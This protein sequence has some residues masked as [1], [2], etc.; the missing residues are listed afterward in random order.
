MHSWHLWMVNTPKWKSSVSVS[1]GR[2]RESSLHQLTLSWSHLP[3]GIRHLSQHPYV[4]AI[5]Y[6]SAA[7]LL[8]RKLPSSIPNSSFHHSQDLVSDI[9]VESDSLILSN[10]TLNV[11]K[12]INLLISVLLNLHGWAGRFCPEQNH[13]ARPNFMLSVYHWW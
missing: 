7:C 6:Y 12:Y 2:S 13:T 11:I 5:Q 9:P 10:V 1:S 8:G 3:I 4:S